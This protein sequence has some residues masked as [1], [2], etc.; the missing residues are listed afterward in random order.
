MRSGSADPASGAARAKLWMVAQTSPP[1]NC[2]RLDPCEVCVSFTRLI[3]ACLL[4]AGFL[5]P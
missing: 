3:A 4:V 2:G 5:I 1:V